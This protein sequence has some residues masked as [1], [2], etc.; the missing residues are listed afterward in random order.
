ME[1]CFNCL[2]NCF[3]TLPIK[4]QSPEGTRSR[5]EP[6]GRRKIILQLPSRVRLTWVEMGYPICAKS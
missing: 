5:T 3:W 1:E 6:F 2:F 4:L